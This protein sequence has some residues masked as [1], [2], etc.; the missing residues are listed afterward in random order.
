[1][2]RVTLA[3]AIRAPE[4]PRHA[5]NATSKVS[6]ATLTVPVPPSANE[7]HRHVGNRVLLSSAARKYV[8]GL[9][10]HLPALQPF[11]GPIRVEIRWFRA[12]KAGDVDKRGGILLDALQGLAYDN[13]SQIA[14]YRIVRDDSQPRQ[15]R[16]VVTITPIQEAA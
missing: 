8:K 12:R 10:A 14:D 2:M 4:T 11:T 16:M 13:D 5:P 6:A 15:A 9:A 1:M 3:D 7:W